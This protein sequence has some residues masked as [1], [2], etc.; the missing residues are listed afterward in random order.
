VWRSSL[1]PLREGDGHQLAQKGGV[2][3]RHLGQGL[4]AHDGRI[5]AWRRLEGLGRHVQHVFDVVAPL[6]HHRQAPVVLAARPGRHALDDFLLQHECWSSTWSTAPSRW[7][8]I[9]VEML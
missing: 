6:Q 1:R 5:D 9:G 8:R 4:H 7:N 3:A 2:D